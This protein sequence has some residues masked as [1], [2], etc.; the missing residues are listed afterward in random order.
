MV[1][2]P[3][4]D[5]PVHGDDIVEYR[6]GGT[7]HPDHQVNPL[8]DTG[9]LFKIPR[10]H[11]VLATGIGDTVIDDSNLA[12]V[13]DIRALKQ[14]LDRVDVQRLDH[15]DT[16]LTQHLHLLTLQEAGAAD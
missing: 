12:V 1:Y 9:L 15:I 5:R 10:V 13:A 2:F 8:A 7:F 14:H 6:H 11:Q 16:G 3:G 4:L